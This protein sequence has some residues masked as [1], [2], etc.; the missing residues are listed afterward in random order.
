MKGG[1]DY[2]WFAV[3]SSYGTKKLFKMISAVIVLHSWAANSDLA[4]TTRTMLVGW[5][6]HCL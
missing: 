6:T 3:I 4:S 2:L 5:L 1:A